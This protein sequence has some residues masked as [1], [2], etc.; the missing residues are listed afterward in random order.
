[1]EN[2]IKF[3]YEVSALKRIKR[4]GWW[5]E[6]I[7][8]PET[9]AEHSYRTVML[10]YILAKM[11]GADVDKVVKMCL[12]HDM[13]ECRINDVPRSAIKY[14]NKDPIEKEVVK[15]QA[16]LLPAQIATEYEAIFNEM[17]GMK[18]KEAIVAKDAD[19]LET[20]IQAKE[21]SDMGFK[22]CDNWVEKNSMNLQTESAKKIAIELK[23]VSFN[24]WHRGMAKSR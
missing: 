5:L 24:E 21:Y 12:F 2:L 1:M 7:K 17:D 20:I 19:R 13:P 10:G 23:K 14:L 15:D 4:S 18:T 8:D 16:R 3:L 22:G 6:G 9:V 11:E